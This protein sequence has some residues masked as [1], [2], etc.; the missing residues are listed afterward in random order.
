MLLLMVSPLRA[1]SFP[2]DDEPLNTVD[3]HCKLPTVLFPVLRRKLFVFHFLS[4]Y[5]FKKT[6]VL[7]TNV[8]I[9]TLVF[10][11]Q[12]TAMLGIF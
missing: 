3:Y 5:T 2:E 7:H 9:I 4:M 8:S 1:V 11:E 6:T 10:G 12:G